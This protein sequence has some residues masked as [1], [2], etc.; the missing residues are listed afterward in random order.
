MFVDMHG[1]PCAKLVPVAALEQTLD[2]GA[3]F[4][5]YAAGPIG[6]T[7]GGPG[8]DRD[9]GHRDATPRCRGG[10]ASRS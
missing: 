1:K 5:G 7:P 2:E 6:Q 10:R 9:A 3:G 4:A 8:P